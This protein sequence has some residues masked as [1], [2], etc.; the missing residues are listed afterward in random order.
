MKQAVKLRRFAVKNPKKLLFALAFG[1]CLLVR[2]GPIAE[3]QE[4]TQKPSHSESLIYSLKGPDLFRAYCASCHGLSGKGD[5]PAAPALKA[6][7]PDLTLL[8]MRHGGYF[9]SAFV[10][11]LIAGD[12]FVASHGS[13]EMPIWGPIFHRVEE[14]VDFGNVRLENLVKYLQ[15]IQS[16]AASSHASGAELYKE[17]CAVCH[18]DDLKGGSPAPYP[19]RMPPDLTTLARRHGGQFPEVYVSEVLRAGVMLPAHGPAEMPVW[20]TAL[21]VGERLNQAQVTMRISELVNYISS[22]QEK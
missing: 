18:G 16:A 2:V 15:S 11:D 21:E 14:D 17:R 9:P 10:K 1:V 7:V 5:G 22:H 19:Y 3:A 8:A 12:S 20:G 13:R 4:E 6:K